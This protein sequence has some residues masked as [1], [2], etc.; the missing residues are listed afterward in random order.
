MNKCGSYDLSDSNTRSVRAGADQAVCTVVLCL[1]S[2]D[3]WSLRPGFATSLLCNSREV[4]AL[5]LVLC[6]SYTIL[7]PFLEFLMPSSSTNLYS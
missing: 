5:P 7:L 6:S 4:M 3:S 1:H 2:G